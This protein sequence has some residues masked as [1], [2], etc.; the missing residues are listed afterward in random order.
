MEIIALYGLFACDKDG[1][2]LNY[3]VHV[4]QHKSRSPLSFLSLLFLRNLVIPGSIRDS[5]LSSQAAGFEVM[6]FKLGPQ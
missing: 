5:S 4:L 3:W 2:D 1:F 6:N